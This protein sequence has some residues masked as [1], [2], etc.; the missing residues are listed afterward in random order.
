MLLIF[1]KKPFDYNLLSYSINRAL[2]TQKTELAYKHGKKKLQDAN[3]R[4]A[5]SNEALSTLA[6]N[7]DRSRNDVEANI[8]KKIRLSILPIIEN[9]QQSKDLSQDHHLDLDLLMDLVADL[10]STREDQRA[11]STILTSTEFRIAVLIGE[12]LTTNEISRHMHI[13]SETVKSH[14]KNIR[15]KLNL[16]NT[17]HN[18]CAYLR[19]AL[20]R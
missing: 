15:K 13:S 20:D 3:R 6:K 18:L 19:S 17:H 8:E 12:N 9:L 10:A 16:N 2:E 7:L 14:R 5:E 4:L 11:L 1:W